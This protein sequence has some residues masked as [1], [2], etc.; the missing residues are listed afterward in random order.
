MS[1]RYGLIAVDSKGDAMQLEKVTYDI[2]MQ[3][4][5]KEV[6]QVGTSLGSFS[7]SRP[8]NGYNT[9]L[10]PST[11]LLALALVVFILSP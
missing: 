11:W 7:A 3:Y 10:K 8:K 5:P 2:A 4:L 9:D 6:K 1:P